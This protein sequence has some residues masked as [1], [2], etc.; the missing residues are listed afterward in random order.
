METNSKQIARALVLKCLRYEQEIDAK[1]ER[2]NAEQRH[3][4]F[5]RAFIASSVS[6]NDR[7]DEHVEE[8]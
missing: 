4:D 2:S 8:S 3:I 5:L 6:Q 1:Q 7:G